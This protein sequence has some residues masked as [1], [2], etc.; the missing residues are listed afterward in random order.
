MSPSPSIHKRAE[1]RCVRVRKRAYPWKVS[2]RKR[3]R[4]LLPMGL[5]CCLRD[6]RLKRMQLPRLAPFPHP[7]YC[8]P[9]ACT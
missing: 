8:Y 6:R 5:H 4:T 1:G 2:V 3:T 7:P 9:G